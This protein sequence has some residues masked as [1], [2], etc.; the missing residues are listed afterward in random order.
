[1][2]DIIRMYEARERGEKLPL[3]EYA[4]SL[5]YV[6]PRTFPNQKRGYKR[7]QISWGGPS[8]EFRMYSSPTVIEF[9]YLDWFDGAKITLDPE[10]NEFKVIRS[11]MLH[12]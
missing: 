1:M 11:I 3:N 10:S 6:E 5:D 4:L 12:G 9:W 2:A 7:Y 8:E